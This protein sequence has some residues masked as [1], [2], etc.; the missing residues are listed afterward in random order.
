MGLARRWVAWAAV[1]ACLSVGMVL[2][3]CGAGT[4]KIPAA[5]S[6][7]GRHS[8]AS[9]KVV[10]TFTEYTSGPGISTFRQAWFRNPAGGTVTNTISSSQ[11]ANK[12]PAMKFVYNAGSP[13]YAGLEHQMVQNNNWSGYA[14]YSVWIK[15]DG[16]KDKLVVQF[17]D[18]NGEQ[19]D[20]YPIL[21]F[22]NWKQLK[23][24]F[25]RF[26]PAPWQ[27]NPPNKIASAS[28]LS[29]IQQISFYVSPNVKGTPGKGTIYLGDISV[30]K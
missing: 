15:G 13:G 12:L 2:A 4:A 14:G 18:G 3:G 28:V 30:Y 19:W 8:A 24:P 21:D 6:S 29:K 1:A 7:T 17:E 27:K 10:E 5:K 9:S 11:K 16:S 22:T 26:V 20:S 23:V 25:S